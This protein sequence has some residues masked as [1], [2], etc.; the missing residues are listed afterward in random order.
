V[1]QEEHLQKAVRIVLRRLREERRRVQSRDREDYFRIDPFILAASVW[2]GEP[3]ETAAPAEKLRF[4]ALYEIAC[5]ALGVPMHAADLRPH[6]E[7]CAEELDNLAEA[8]SWIGCAALIREQGISKH[9]DSLL[10]M[11]ALKKLRARQERAKEEADEL[12][13][14]RR[15]K[16][17][18]R[19]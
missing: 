15:A 10:N 9:I 3:P 1:S 19:H 16:T 5:N 6:R 8:Y 14:P 12:R 11:D 18:T 17:E 2:E 7:R 13:T 4:Q